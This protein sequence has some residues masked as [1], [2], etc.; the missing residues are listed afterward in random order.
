MKPLQDAAAR[1]RITSD[2]D[3]NL[4]VEAGAGSGKTTMLVE[5]MLA[6]VERG[7]PVEQVAAVT[8]TRKAAAEL[9]ERFE[10]KLERRAAE[11][12][13]AE[14]AARL[15]VARD[16]MDRAFLGTIHSF[17]ARL[18]REH[19]LEAGL[20][21][22][23]VEVPE[24]E[25]PAIRAGFWRSWIER[26]RVENDPS[27]D[28]LRRLNLDPRELF[29]AFE[30]RAKYPDVTFPA[31][32][33]PAPDA[34]RCRA[35]LDALLDRA[36]EMMPRDKPDGGWDQAQALFRRLDRLRRGPDWDDLARFADAM[37]E[38]DD[39]KFTMIRWGVRARKDTPVH[40]LREDLQDFQATHVIP[41]I[42][43]WRAHRYAP[44]M[45]FIERAAR[46]FAEQRH[47]RGTLVFEDLLQLAARLLRESPEAR[48]R[49]GER[50]RRLLVDE[51]QDTDP[52]QAEVCFLLAS[53]PE[54]GNNWT[55]VTPRPGAL[56]VVGDPKQSIYRFRRADI[57]TYELVKRCIARVGAVLQLTRN[58]RSVQAIAELVNAH[59][60]GPFPVESSGVQAAF[61]PLISDKATEPGDGVFSYPVRPP[62]SNKPQIIATCAEQVAS[63]IRR[64]LDSGSKSSEFMVLTTGKASLACYASALV[65]RNIPV[66]VTGAGLTAGHELEE[67]L[68]LLRA[69]ADPTNEVLVVAALEGLFA[70]LTPEQ[71]LDVRRR[72]ARFHLTDAPPDTSS[73][74]GAALARLHDWWRA[75]QQLPPDAL[76]ERIVDQT[77]LLPH[78]ASGTL[79]DNAAGA[80]AEV[81]AV[82][83]RS[84]MDGKASLA[85]V[86]QRI[87]A[88]MDNSD[89]EASLRPGLQDAVRVLNLHK[90]K[91]LEARVVILAAPVAMW[92]ISAPVHVS[93]DQD[94]SASGGMTVCAGDR[95]IAEPADWKEMH[96]REVSFLDAEFDRLLY[97]AV[98]RAKRELWVAKFDFD[99]KT[100]KAQDKSLWARLSAPLSTL[101]QLRELPMDNPPGRIRV[102]LSAVEIAG[103]AATAAA[104]RARAGLPR[105]TRSTVTRLAR[106][107]AAEAEELKL[108]AKRGLGRNWGSAVH[109]CLEAMGR[110][111][112]GG[113]LERFVRAVARS[114]E[115]RDEQAEQ[116]LA[117]VLEHGASAEW[118]RMMQ[119][120]GGAAVELQIAVMEQGSEGVPR[121]VEGVIDAVAQVN[122][123]WGVVDWKTD[124]LEGEAW[125][126]R[127]VQYQRQV[128]AYARMLQDQ[129]GRRATGRVV[130]VGREDG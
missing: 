127:R 22:T 95:T 121:L 60:P 90:A 129:T 96:A 55:S 118:R 58:F 38:K 19:P 72:G 2:L 12:T 26:C 88:A 85:D 65:A 16:H 52:I 5:R 81:I 63:M 86:M 20:D 79:G 67:L 91:G 43:A 25:W 50:Y 73:P 70:G 108:V 62:E 13:D 93:R 102:E 112:S 78:T 116:L 80:I 27:L 120:K 31:P 45:H 64:R 66:S 4:L 124:N 23:F 101:G 30:E 92:D 128:D 130:R 109:E 3:A 40:Q 71:L 53:E 42:R 61:A 33:V 113:N 57:T 8:F 29:E 11:A 59:F 51:F 103:I 34:T 39:I 77:G 122:G 48:R 69:I 117:L 32:S 21:P 56:F 110:G 14:A 125:E 84:A 82:A 94:G 28:T 18:L 99:L 35:A 107:E 17:A 89:S 1:T 41:L 105:W 49:L 126:G 46:A 100:G 54:Q 75:S 9:R 15:R 24:E 44:V 6:L 36:R 111:R 74:A 7:T 47:A 76:L 87:E 104:R 106:E 119:A 37:S 83:R 98:T 97:V 115:L 68:I 114:H 10:N 123:E